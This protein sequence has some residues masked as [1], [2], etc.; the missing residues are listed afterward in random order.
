MEPM[1]IKAVLGERYADADE[2][3][4]GRVVRRVREFIDKTTGIQTIAQMQGLVKIIREFGIV[5]E[6]EI[7]NEFEYKAIYL[8]ALMDVVSVRLAKLRRNELDL[9]DFTV[10]SAP[11]F[12]RRLRTAGVKLYLASGTDEK[13]VVA[14]AEALGYAALFE[15]RIYG[16]VQDVSVEAKRMVLER[17][18]KDIGAANVTQV[19]TFGDGPVEIRETRK[20]GGIAVGIA[21]DE[22]RRYGLTPAKRTRLIRAGAH[23][24]VPDFSQLNQLLGLIGLS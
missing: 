17:I 23:L 10:K 16:A 21:S 20:R 4:Y 6:A 19:V 14:E 11:Q 5:P 8:E 12:L 22:V 9:A 13:D 24:V 1:M 15:G 7:H 18:L 2:T 3:L